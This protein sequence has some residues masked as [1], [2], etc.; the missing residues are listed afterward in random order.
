MRARIATVCQTGRFY[1]SIEGNR[2]YVMGLLDLALRQKPD[3]VCLPEAFTTASVIDK[4]L[5]ELSEPVPGPTTE[6]IAKRARA[7]K[8]YII[9]PIE[10]RRGSKLWNS[11]IVIDRS[12]DVLDIYDTVYPSTTSHDYTVFQNGV[13]PGRKVPVFDLDFGCIGIQICFDVGFPE[14]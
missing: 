11:A 6:A 4:P 7:S 12:G 2:K 3:L 14:S 1:N 9:C 13:T 8:C 10:T 5:K